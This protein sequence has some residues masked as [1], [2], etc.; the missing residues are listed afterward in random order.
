MAEAIG[1]VWTEQRLEQLKSLWA[2]GLSISQIGAEIGV[3]RNAVV[4]KVHRMGL[5][6]RQSPIMRSE[7]TPA[8]R[9]A[10]KTASPMTFEEWDRSKCCWPIGDPKSDDFRFC[11]ERASEGRPYCAHHCAMAYTTTRESNAS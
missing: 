8:V 1:S 10:A 6:K 2:K 4:G 3:S 11:G 5:P 7:K 9:P